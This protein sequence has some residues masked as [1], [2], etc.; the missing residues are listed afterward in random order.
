MPRSSSGCESRPGNRYYEHRLIV[1]RERDL[2]MMIIKAI[3]E[4]EVG[5]ARIMGQPL[6]RVLTGRAPGVTV[7]PAR[8]NGSWH[9]H[10]CFVRQHGLPST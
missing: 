10:F 1:L 2:R 7:I 9:F 4:H 8:G 6:R 3:R 5:L